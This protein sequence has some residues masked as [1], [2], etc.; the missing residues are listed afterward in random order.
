MSKPTSPGPNDSFILRINGEISCCEE[1]GGKLFRQ[2]PPRDG[3]ER[4]VCKGCH[5]AY[6]VKGG[7]E[8]PKLLEN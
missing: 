1:C 7:D 5:A 3:I 6:L 8:P 2:L 4:F